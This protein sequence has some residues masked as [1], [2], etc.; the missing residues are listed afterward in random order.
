M[1]NLFWGV[2]W[3]G[4][5]LALVLT[6]LIALLIGETPGGA[7]FWWDFSIG[8][9]FA[10]MAMMGVQ[11]ILTARFR[12][13]TAPYG[14]DIIYFFHRYL[15]VIALALVLAHPIILIVLNPT[16][17]FLL[18]PLEAPWHMTAGVISAAAMILL[19]A[20]SLWRKQ[21]RIHYDGWRIAH[22][23]FAIAAMVFALIHVEKVGYYIAAPWKRNLWTL[24]VICWIAV[25][26]YVRLIKPWWISRRPYRVT[27]VRPERGNSWTVALE[28]DGHAGIEFES[29]QFVWLTLRHSPF[30]MKEHPFSISSSPT[31][32]DRLEFTIK[33]LGDFTRTI[34]DVEPGE[35]AYVDGPYGAFSVERHDAPGYAFIAGGIG[36]APIASM[37]RAL[38]DRGDSRPLILFSAHSSWER[39]TLRESVEELR[40]RLDLQIVHVLEEPHEGWEGETGYVNA[41]MLDRRLPA[42]RSQWEYFICGPVPMIDAVE[43][44]LHELGIP[45]SKYHTELFDLV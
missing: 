39:A 25:I 36:I 9:G 31:L 20:T 34:G 43:K 1:K 18:N 4:V 15:A 22:V 30:S 23:V 17:L 13:A 24:I 16:F 10:G 32:R 21:L 40:G 44:A 3:I 26:V 35:T 8:L 12:R 37:L 2:F 27:E 7:G 29:G 38:A 14:I 5:Y 45:M 41:D 6:P 28:P 42:E 19:V 11:F 33:E